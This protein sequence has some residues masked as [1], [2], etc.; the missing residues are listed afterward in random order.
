[1]IKVSLRFH[2]A[3]SSTS[4]NRDRL[5]EHVGDVMTELIKIEACDDRVADP[6][7]A[8]DLSCGS[9][10]IELVVD[11]ETVGQAAD[12]GHNTIRTAIQAAGGFTPGWG[13]PSGRDDNTPTVEGA[14]DVEYDLDNL[15]CEPA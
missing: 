14:D 9:V 4:G 8:L 12:Y 11:G 6:S 5:S 7:V 10:E 15:V 3:V 13:A 2:L 1:M